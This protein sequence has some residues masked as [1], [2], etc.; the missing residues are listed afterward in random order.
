[1]SKAILKKSTLPARV[2]FTFNACKEC[3][4]LI[5]DSHEIAIGTRLKALYLCR[6][7]LLQLSLLQQA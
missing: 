7:H 3:V 4:I 5:K 1:M 6:H 2:F